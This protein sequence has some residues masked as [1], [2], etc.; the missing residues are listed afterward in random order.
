MTRMR[1][2][3]CARFLVALLL[4]PNLAIRVRRQV[5]AV[6][7]LA[8]RLDPT[9]TS[10]RLRWI[11]RTHPRSQRIN[12]GASTV[13]GTIPSISS[14]VPPIRHSLALRL[15]TT[16]TRWP[17]WRESAVHPRAK[18]ATRYV[19]K[20]KAPRMRWAQAICFGSGGSSSITT[21]TSPTRQEPAEPAPIPVPAGDPWFDPTGGGL[22]TIEFNRSAYHPGTGHDPA[23]PAA[24]AQSH[25][26]LHRRVQRLR[27]R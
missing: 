5:E 7:A 22:A 25:H 17:R 16:A 10:I 26:A 11:H 4:V 13:R 3:L 21:S 1:V 24:T 8:P 9:T 12:T 23:Y 27:L 15:Q 20:R 18:S 2:T 19:P 6:W 14:S